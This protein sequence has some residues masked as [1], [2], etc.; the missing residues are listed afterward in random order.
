MDQSRLSASRAHELFSYDPVTGV[1]TRK[2]AT[3]NSVKVG[4]VVGSPQSNGYLRVR[5]GKH[6]LH[7]HRL[8][9][10]LHTGE[11]PQNTVDHRNGIRSDNR[12][13]NLR[14]L[15]KAVNNQN[16]HG[17]WAVSGYAGVSAAGLRFSS[18]VTTRGAQK[19]LG[20][21]DTPEEAHQAYLTAKRA[22]HEGC[23]I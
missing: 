12:A 23:T 21:F 13:S 18:K 14:D 20:T 6:L 2:I 16:A 1:I 7:V 22:L 8:A 3:T 19:Y 9:W 15:P 4:D 11:W 5:V 17:T 10:L